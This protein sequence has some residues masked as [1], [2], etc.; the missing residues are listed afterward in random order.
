M[1]K[2]LAITLKRACI[3]ATAK[4]GLSVKS[5]DGSLVKQVNPMDTSVKFAEPFAWTEAPGDH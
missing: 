1:N 4:M 3:S 2:Q 5:L